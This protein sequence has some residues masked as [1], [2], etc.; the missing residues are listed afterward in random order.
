MDGISI[1]LIQVPPQSR[2]SGPRD[3]SGPP[4]LCKT[5]PKQYATALPQSVKN[6][7]SHH[8]EDWSPPHPSSL[9]C[10]PP[11]PSSPDLRCE[12]VELRA[13]LNSLKAQLSFLLLSQEVPPIPSSPDAAPTVVL[14]PCAISPTSSISTTLS[15][16]APMDYAW[17]QEVLGNPNCLTYLHVINSGMVP[18]VT[19]TMP[20]DV[21]Q[22][23]M[24]MHPRCPPIYMGITVTVTFV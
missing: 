20:D 23:V 8:S 15:C 7:C 3:G 9:L 1:P 5:V 24:V 10:F 12:I 2:G 16:T 17:I 14:E 21:P 22:A 4:G 19:S 13:E 6:P 18:S 11:P